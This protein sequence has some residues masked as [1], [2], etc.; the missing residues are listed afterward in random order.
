VPDALAQPAPRPQPASKPQPDALP[1]G[2]AAG[3]PGSGLAPRLA[4]LDALRGIAALC[5]VFDHL[6][7]SV[8][9]PV[10]D[11]VYS[12]FDPGQ[13]GVFVF[14][15]VSGYIVPA[16]LER[17][18]SVR[19][20]WV[21]RVFR[22][23]PLY[24]FAVGAMIVL[25]ASGIGS[26]AGMNTDTVT[27]SFAD[28]FMLQS[29]LWAP[30][31]PNV[32][33]SL[34]YEMVFYLLLTALFLGG[35]HRRS[36]RYALVFAVAALT[37]GRVLHPGS[38]SFDLFTPGVVVAITD[39]LVLLGLVLVLAGRGRSRT[40]GGVL[41][42]A[43][44]L[45]VVIF[46]SGFAAPWE[47]FTIFALMF[48]GTMLYRAETGGYPWR[49]AI[50]VV[51]LV[52]GL[53]LVAA[54]LHTSPESESLVAI[55]KSFNSLELA[56]LTFAVAMLCR[57]RKIPRALAWL[58]LVSYSVYLLHPALIEV[59]ASV[60]WTQ[61]QNFVPTELLLVTVFV[62]VLLACCGLTH[63]FIEMP[64]QR[65]GRRVAA[66]LDARFGPDVRAPDPDPVVS[67]RPHA[68]GAGPPPR[69]DP[70]SPRGDHESSRFA[71]S[72]P[73]NAGS[74]PW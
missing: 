1:P 45:L 13:Y 36:S 55:R 2:S 43:T 5:V 31:L 25:W 71:P 63:R 23:Y 60:P 12:W 22:L 48:T 17:R 28:V 42:A 14:F 35:V 10:R 46:N 53:V 44:G 7:Y 16:S 49:R 3:R 4:W 20:F 52:F 21:G 8:L 65:L 11:S 66:R 27:A 67:G 56:G 72:P 19:G 26:L 34:A 54:Q 30:T 40:A 62:A 68:G 74:R 33:W 32:V 58:G 29:V 18:G 51:I 9:Q 64:M 61:N 73:A 70:R 47:S 39:S 24:L 41:A 38:L 59:Y 6:T 15:L 37:L 50:Y 69:P 57:R